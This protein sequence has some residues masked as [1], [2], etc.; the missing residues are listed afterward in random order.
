MSDI[1]WEDPPPAHPSQRGAPARWP[2]LLPRLVNAP[3]RWAKLQ[4]Y[5]SYE[6]A[7]NARDYLVRHHLDSMPGTWEAVARY[8]DPDDRT[9]GADLYARYLGDGEA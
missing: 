8:T 1:I 3:G 4:H 5:R 7:R 6:S 2:D 9:K